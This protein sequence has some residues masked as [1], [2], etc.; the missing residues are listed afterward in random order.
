MSRTIDDFRNLLSPDRSKVTFSIN[1]VVAKVLSMMQPKAK[2]EVSTEDECF[3]EGTRNEYSQVIINIIAN[4]HDV[5]RERQIQDP[6]IAIRIFR[7][8]DRSVVTI[9]DNGG[10]IPTEI[11]GKIFDPYFTTKGPD[12]GTGIGLFM[13]KTIIERSM[14]GALTARNTEG[15][16]EFRIEV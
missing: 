13:S 3:A 7:E 16:A 10:G 6:R 14:K 11:I 12:Q 8:H 4:A 5:F 2:V 15:G 9:A 1:D